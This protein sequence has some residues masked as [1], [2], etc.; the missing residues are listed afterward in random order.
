M[1]RLP[2][3]RAARARSRIS[4]RKSVEMFSRRVRQ[5]ESYLQACGISVPE[6]FH[7]DANMLQWLTD[8]YAPPSDTTLAVGGPVHNYLETLD[9]NVCASSSQSNV[10]QTV[11]AE[12]GP[13]ALFGNGS[14]PLSDAN[15][16]SQQGQV[17]EGIQAGPFSSIDFTFDADLVWSSLMLPA[18]NL[19][20]DGKMS[21]FCPLWPMGSLPADSQ[22]HDD[23]SSTT[24]TIPEDDESTDD[25]EHSEITAQLSGR[26]GT[27]LRA[28]N[29]EWRFYGA[30]SNLHLMRDEHAARPPPHDQRHHKAQVRL[31]QAGLGHSVSR[32]LITHL[33]NL[34]FTWQDPSLHV[35][36]RFAFEAARERYIDSYEETGLYSELLVNSICAI[37][38]SF[39][40]ERHPELPGPLNEFFANRAKTILDLD[41]ESPR[42]ST[43]QALTILSTHEGATSQDTRGWLYSGMA[44][45]LAYDLGLHISPAKYVTSGVMSAEEARVR[46]VAFWGA[47]STDRM[48][49][50]YLG[51]PFHNNLEDIHVERPSTDGT[52]SPKQTW[53]PYGTPGR[54]PP[55]LPSSQE[56]LSARWVALYF[57]VDVTKIELV[58]LGEETLN[59]LEKW[60]S[61][62]PEEL[63]VDINAL[64]AKIHLP[65]TLIMQ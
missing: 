27:L 25:E 26:L 55:A 46:R 47:F 54:D 15:D 45:R 16:V 31:E 44:I 19:G 4:L 13:S 20:I 62:M 3:K 63:A 42:I 33:A 40:R 39:E 64:D 21:D 7:A 17:L 57:R 24:H 22:R 60:K 56:L 30:T 14:F 49:G 36:D 65:Q 8:S 61:D 23:H 28:P 11:N 52:E 37:G 10:D 12:S 41:L 2:V 38:A 18:P 51:R 59:K 5:L 58:A 9:I 48:W 29:G 53:A 43:V 6:P 35:V 1:S 32:E 50:F 34:Y